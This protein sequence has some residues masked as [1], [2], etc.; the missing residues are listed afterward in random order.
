MV[1]PFDLGGRGG[2]GVGGCT[3]VVGSCA[4]PEYVLHASNFT[5]LP[6]TGEGRRD[7]RL[8]CEI[9][10]PSNLCNVS[11]AASRFHYRFIP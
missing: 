11:L 7:R 5:F 10:A 6:A 9:L 3:R 4:L 1:G 8:A 2:G